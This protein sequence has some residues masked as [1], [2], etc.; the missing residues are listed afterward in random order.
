MKKGFLRIFIFVF[1]AISGFAYFNYTWKRFERERFDEVLQIGNTIVATLPKEDLKALELGSVDILNPGYQHLKNTLKAVIHVNSK[2]R[3]A[4]LYC[5]KNGNIFFIA[6]SE[7]ET[8]AD[9]SPPG[10]EFPEASLQDKQPFIDGKDLVTDPVTDRW[11]TWVSV[12]IPIKEKSTG[13]VIAVFGMDFNSK[14]WRNSLLYEL[15]E[16]CLL[17]LLLVMAAVLLLKIKERNIQLNDDISK[18]IQVEKDLILAKDM[19]EES[20]R[21][22]SAFLNNLSHEIRTPMN[23]IQGAAYLLKDSMLDANEQKVY[24]EII[25]SGVKR[26]LNII[27]NIIDISKIESGVITLSISKVNVSTQLNDLCDFF[28]PECRD[29]GIQFLLKMESEGSDESIETDEKKLISI[30]SNL[31]ENAIKF[32]HHGVI[33][34]GC[35]KK[36]TRLEF[37]VKDTGVGIS[38]DK[39]EIIFQKFRQG[40]ESHTR[41]YE[42]AGLGLSISKA[43]VEKLGGQIWFESEVGKG[44]TF[45]VV[46]PRLIPGNF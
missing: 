10:Q 39:K 14:L 34:F 38:E 2:A 42:G 21:L 40:G 28:M 31:L 18:R 30:L 20:D 32:T 36:D 35:E 22:K 41:D 23:G 33:E 3:F 9:Y 17:F 15:S 1:M 13:Q 37:F 11:G 19:A 4:Y 44:S 12:L 43:Y 46:L 24:L 29:K 27:N 25:E 26:L 5:N 7:P 16:S 6:D 45:Y 8:S